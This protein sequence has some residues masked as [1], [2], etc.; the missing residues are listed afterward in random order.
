M[1]PISVVSSV[2]GT[3]THTVG[4]FVLS[5]G[6]FQFV[7]DSTVRSGGPGEAPGSLD[8]LVASLVSCALGALRAE[9]HRDGDRHV[10]VFGRVERDVES[11]ESI[12]TIVLEFFIADVTDDQ[13]QEL[14][15]Q[16][17][18]RCRIYVALRDTV[19]IRILAHGVPTTM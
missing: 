1:P 9:D 15:A 4:R 7:S 12:G 19:A 10:E 5:S 8:L 16:Y 14:A 17:Q 2:E 6:S 3:T 18:E 11:D 13:A